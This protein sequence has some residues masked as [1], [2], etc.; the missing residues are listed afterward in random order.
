MLLSTILSLA[1][2]AFA[3]ISDDSFERRDAAINAAQGYI[4]SLPALV[5]IDAVLSQIPGL[6]AHVTKTWDVINGFHLAESASPLI[7]ALSALPGVLVEKDSLMSIQAAATQTNAPWNLQRISSDSAVASRS[8]TKSQEGAA[9]YTFKYDTSYAGSNVQVYVVDTGINCDHQAFGGRATCATDADF[10]NSGSSYDGNGHGTHCAG[11]IG[12]SPYGVAKNTNL[13]AVRVLGSDGSGSTSN[14]ISGIQYVVNKKKNSG[15][16]TVMSMSLGG[17][18][19]TSLTNAVN[20]AISNGVHTVVA[21]GNSY[22]DACNSS[23]SDSNAIVVGA[24]NITDTFA[25]FSNYGSCVDVL[26]PGFNILSAWK[27]STTATNIISGTS[28]ATPLTAGVIVELL[29]HSQYAN[30]SPSQIRT[31][32]LNNAEQNV[33]SQVPDQTNNLLVQYVY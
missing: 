10:T 15:K 7:A 23:P 21:A 14:I 29:S 31:L 12:S 17:G 28:M 25:Y 19:S 26:A 33:I 3:S 6:N 16:P 20:S 9:A 8:T 5:K 4:V 1:G 18:K 27:G 30:Y 13:F 32:L 11:T 24:T 2:G 22:A